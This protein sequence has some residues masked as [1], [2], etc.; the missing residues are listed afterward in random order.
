MAGA[1]S[2][3]DLKG[4]Q[5]RLKIAREGSGTWEAI[6]SMRSASFSSESSRCVFHGVGFDHPVEIMENPSMSTN[7]PSPS[8]TQS[9]RLTTSSTSI[10]SSL[11][12]Q[13]KQR[14]PEPR[15]FSDA[16]F[17]QRSTPEHHLLEAGGSL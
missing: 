14:T 2:R 3:P 12:G 9:E 1:S 6:A 13:T 4:G 16:M 7:L 10:S 15:S 5:C 8:S 11:P 17:I